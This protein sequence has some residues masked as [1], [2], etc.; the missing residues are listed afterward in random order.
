MGGFLA[1]LG[2]VLRDEAGLDVEALPLEQRGTHLPLHPPI[3][4]ITPHIHYSCPPKG[5]NTLPDQPFTLDTY[6]G[7]ISYFTALFLIKS[8]PDLNLDYSL[9]NYR[10]KLFLE[11]MADLHVHLAGVLMEFKKI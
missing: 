3:N 8:D 4:I 10:P 6:H 5:R 1:V 11:G 2:R 9:R 7:L